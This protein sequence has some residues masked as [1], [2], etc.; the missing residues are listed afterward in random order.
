MVKVQ[1][2]LLQNLIMFLWSKMVLAIYFIFDNLH[3][4]KDLFYVVDLQASLDQEI[5]QRT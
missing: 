1:A 5:K 2:F 4:D 3:N